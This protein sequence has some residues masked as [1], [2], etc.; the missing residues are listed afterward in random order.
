MTNKYTQLV[1]SLPMRGD[2]ENYIT[3]IDKYKFWNLE[4]FGGSI[5][6]HR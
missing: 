2:F 3:E 5:I 4:M 6:L 1:P